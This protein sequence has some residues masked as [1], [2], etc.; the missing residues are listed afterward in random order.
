MKKFICLL[1][2][3]LLFFSCQKKEVSTLPFEVTKNVT[4]NDLYEIGYK[5]TFGVDVVLI[6]KKIINTTIYYQIDLPLVK[7][8]IDY[9]DFDEETLLDTITQSETKFDKYLK[10]DALTLKDSIYE[11]VWG[12][13]QKQ[14]RDV[15]SE[16]KVSWRNFMLELKKEETENYRNTIDTNKYK[17][18]NINIDSD[19]YI[20]KFKVVNVIT[21]DT[22]NCSVY[23]QNEKYYFS[24][25]FT[26]IN[27]E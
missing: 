26:L 18:L 8:K 23:E 15:C 11:F 12:D 17:I 7:D 10:Q 3:T 19:Y 21:K 5:R 20:D 16:G 2:V 14:K 13:I 1:I 25:T 24:S 9:E 22:F 4:C 27:Y 6:G